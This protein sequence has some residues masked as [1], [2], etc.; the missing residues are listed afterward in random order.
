[1][2]H[3]HG[4]VTLKITREDDSA[5]RGDDGGYFLI[6]VLR[7]TDASRERPNDCDW[8]PDGEYFDNL[9]AS[10]IINVL[11]IPFVGDS[12]TVTGT[13]T[14]SSRRGSWD[15]DDYDE[16]FD[17][18]VKKV[19]NR[20]SAGRKQNRKWRK[21]DDRWQALSAAAGFQK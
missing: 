4:K 21:A 17:V 9:G 13:W 16:D 20:S 7:M 10:N 19:L 2:A 3:L 15:Y 5:Q 6:E 14:F 18:T 1:M 11:K 8:L 12:I